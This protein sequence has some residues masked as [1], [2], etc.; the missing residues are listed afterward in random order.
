MYPEKF[1]LGIAFVIS[2]WMH[3]FLFVYLSL[4]LS[5]FDLFENKIRQ[6]SPNGTEEQQITLE[7]IE[8]LKSSAEKKDSKSKGEKSGKQQLG[9][10]SFDF[11]KEKWGDLV[12]QLKKADGLKGFKQKFEDLIGN[13]DVSESYIYRGRHYEDI[14]VK[15]VFPTL[16]TINND[17]KQIIKEAPKD[18]DYYNE[19]NKVIN[20]FRK[21]KEGDISDKRIETKIISENAG[22]RKPVLKFSKEERKKYF[23]S[24][25][26]I[27]K[28]EQLYNFVKK[29]FK[30]D[31]DKGD[32]PV[33]TRELY[34]ENLQRLA[35]TFSSDPT[36]FYLDYFEENLNKEDFLK[37]ALNQVSELKGSKTMTEILFALLYIYEI[38]QRAWS[39][40]FEVEKILPQ[41]SK[42]KKEQLRVETLRRVVQKY[43]PA[44]D[45]KGI[46]NYSELADL[47]TK[48]REEIIDFILVNSPKNYRSNDALFEKGRLKW[49]Q[50]V[51]LQNESLLSEAVSIW[52]RIPDSSKDGKENFLNKETIEK[53]KPLL[54]QYMNNDPLYKL[55]IQNSIHNIINSRQFERLNEKRIREEKLLWP[56]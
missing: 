22:G 38:Q 5:S 32:L 40:Y 52:S 7:N 9:A 43:K 35:Y 11:D 24:T 20:N 1:R 27:P 14:T 15:E 48:K 44:L 33:A 26:R 4:Y 30:Y 36:Y 6:G 28:E 34:Y 3:L 18:L 53:I 39:F 25:L 16:S 8:L 37:N 2:F 41:M 47:Y 10:K 12:N 21:W 42:E 46:K 45:K 23:D 51:N 56:K 49:E 31:P 19:R 13:K 55:Q 29:Y 50:G 54:N 17:F